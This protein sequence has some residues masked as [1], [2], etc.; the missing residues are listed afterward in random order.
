[1]NTANNNKKNEHMNFDTFAFSKGFL[2]VRNYIV[3]DITDEDYFGLK[4]E[5]S[6]MIVNM[7]V[8][9]M[10]YGY[11]LDAKCLR[12]L[13]QMSDDEVE[14]VANSIVDYLSDAY[15]DG[16][17]VTLFGNYP[18]TVLNM[19]EFEMFVHQIFHYLSG[20]TYSP[21]MP[22]CDDTE[23]AMLHSQYD[24]RVLKDSYKLITPISDCDLGTYFN[25][26]LSSQQSLTSFDKEAIEYLCKNYEDLGLK[27]WDIFPEDIPFK[28][29]LCLVIVNT[30]EYF[31]KTITDVLRY[32][33][34]I[35]GGDISLPALP[36]MI[37]YGWNPATFARC[38]QRLRERYEKIYRD[39]VND[40]RKAFKFAKFS[41]AQR[42]DI[43]ELMEHVIA[44]NK[45]DNVMADMKKYMGRWI[46][47]GEVLHPGEYSNKYPKTNEA[48]VML[49]NSGQ[50]IGTFNGKIQACRDANDICSLIA[51]YS[52]RPGEFAR[53]IDN[54]LRNY[55]SAAD[56]TLDAFAKVLPSV[57][58]KNIYELLDH[59]FVRNDKEREDRYIVT[60]GARE[61]YKLPTLP[62]LDT[63]VLAKLMS[64]LDTEITN[65]FAAKDSLKGKS[66][67]ID[68]N[69]ANIALPKNMRSMNVAPGQLGRGS[70]LPI[71]DFTGIIRCYCRWVDKFGNYDLDLATQMYD[72]DFK[73]KLSISWNCYYKQENW[74]VFSGDVRHRKG[75][76]AEYID[77][78]INKAL[79][80]GVRY[81]VATVCDYDGG[82]FTKKD[83][84]AGVMA[85]SEFGTPGEL[86]WAPDT[87]TTGFK[88]TSACTNIVMTVI[89]LEEKVMYVVDEDV[90]GIPVASTSRDRL[91]SV[92]K[93]YVTEKRYFNALS[94]IAANITARGGSALFADSDKMEEKM[95]EVE[96][97]KTKYAE[98]IAKY[99]ESIANLKDSNKDDGI[100]LSITLPELEKVYDALCNIE[101][102]TYNDL[103]ADYTK[104]LEWMF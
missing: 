79:A 75:N 58:T 100:V 65:R 1:M 41:R 90:A 24:N 6:Q 3:D 96:A 20:G 63:A 74:A 37:D 23:L 76:C 91:G 50:Y 12:Q 18:Q 84:W 62:D 82:G 68:R 31:P 46:R 39:R 102:I 70:K 93:R 32:A 42:R 29:T 52:T 104:L 21:A 77:I 83:A 2:R 14:K 73:Y 13:S 101:F 5:L 48:F 30:E 54:L 25:K 47:L 43:L 61:A 11:M 89:D 66:Y 81:V 56:D 17:F 15:G 86:T 7:Q 36:T 78:D 88:L 71:D 85:R 64:V 92:A 8:E 35:S 45:W 44:N 16:C 67:I 103:S 4:P 57:S 26:L 9:L 10:R 38:D 34:Y 51:L 95:A 98:L 69:V 55:P 80:S 60:K 97:N 27:F 59:F 19:S 40:A 53:N 22:S 33:V 28:E 87:I 49:R 99:K 94:L 72:K